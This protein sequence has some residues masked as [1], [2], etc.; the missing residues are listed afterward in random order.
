MADLLFIVLTLLC[1]G[2]GHVY[3]TAC[4]RLKVRPK[5]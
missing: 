4:D 3:V 5:P 1:F 2:V